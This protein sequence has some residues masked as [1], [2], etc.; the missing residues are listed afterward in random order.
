MRD[1]SGTL[2]AV[3]AQLSGVDFARRESLFSYPLDV[4]SFAM[5]PGDRYLLAVGGQQLHAVDAGTNR[6]VKT[7]FFD[8]PAAG[9]A[10]GAGAD[11]RNAI[12]YVWLPEEN[13]L[14]FTGLSGLAS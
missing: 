3:P 4:H 2:A 9:V 5:T 7:V 14:F 11:G 13:R 1:E 6:V 10:V 8:S 12:C